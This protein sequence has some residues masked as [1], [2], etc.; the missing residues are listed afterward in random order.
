LT[1]KVQITIPAHIR[2]LLGLS[3]KDRVAFLVSEG[4][5]QIAPASSVVAR[6]AGA[7]K[8]DVAALPPREEKQAAEAAMAEEAEPPAH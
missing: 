4:R 7:L 1:R 3:T 6:T 8:G 5:V 2:R